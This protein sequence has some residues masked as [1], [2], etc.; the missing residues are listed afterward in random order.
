MPDP[1]PM[2]PR[3]QEGAAD[4]A[5]LVALGYEDPP[6]IPEPSPPPPPPEPV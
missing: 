6:P 4:V 1:R 2:E 3:R 5:S